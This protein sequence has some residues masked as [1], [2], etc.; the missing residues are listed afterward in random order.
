MTGDDGKKT[1]RRPHRL[2][3]AAETPRELIL[4][5][6]ETRI[7]RELQTLTAHF[8]RFLSVG[9]KWGQVELFNL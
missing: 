9:A 7:S 4:T 5:F 2:P 8:P 6:R 1:E 3:V